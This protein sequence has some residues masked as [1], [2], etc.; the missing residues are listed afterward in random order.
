MKKAVDASSGRRLVSSRA[1]KKD[2]RPMMLHLRLNPEND[3]LVRE[4]VDSIGFRSAPHVV[5]VL[6]DEALRARGL[7]K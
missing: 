2:R 1:M 4:L 6:V 3:R 7:K 5:D